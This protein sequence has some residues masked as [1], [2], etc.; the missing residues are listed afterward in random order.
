MMKIKFIQRLLLLLFLL[1]ILVGQVD[2]R[3]R[4]H[5]RRLEE[6]AHLLFVIITTTI[7]IIALLSDDQMAKVGNERRR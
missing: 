7:T 4:A 1:F 3:R 5:L 6:R 2:W